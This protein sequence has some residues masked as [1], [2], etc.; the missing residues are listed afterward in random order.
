MIHFHVSLLK[1]HKCS[2]I[3]VSDRGWN[4][5]TRI[6]ICRVCSPTLP[7]IAIFR[8]ISISLLPFASDSLPRWTTALW[9]L[10]YFIT[11]LLWGC[12]PC[13]FVYWLTCV[14]LWSSLEPHFWL[15]LPA[16]QLRNSASKQVISAYSIYQY[17]IMHALFISLLL[18][19]LL[20]RRSPI[21][22]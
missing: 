18:Y 3:S 19:Q 6:W 22:Y 1:E 4:H 8:L 2:A 17:P 12:G 9:H 16:I 15:F 14:F 21:H 7:A 10:Y 11:L 20:S 5:A 13:S